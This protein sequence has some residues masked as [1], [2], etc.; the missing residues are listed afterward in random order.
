MNNEERRRSFRTNCNFTVAVNGDDKEIRAES[1]DI[2]E[3][4]FRLRSHRRF[5]PDSRYELSFTLSPE[6]ANI[7]CVAIVAW[8]NKIDDSDIFLAGFTFSE[9]SQEDM[10]K[11]RK[12]IEERG[13]S[14]GDNDK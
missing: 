3:T 11:I 7:K 2:S 5:T 4:G 13:S 8:I 14:E 12:F 6:V 10:L 1:L 9:L